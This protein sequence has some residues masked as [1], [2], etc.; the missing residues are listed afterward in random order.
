MN[1]MQGH[2]TRRRFTRCLWSA[3]LMLIGSGAV[4]MGLAGWLAR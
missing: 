4:I 1:G 3:A 2:L